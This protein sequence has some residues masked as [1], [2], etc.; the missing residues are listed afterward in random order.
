MQLKINIRISAL[1]YYK[2]IHFFNGKANIVV[3]II[4]IVTRICGAQ[5][6]VSTNATFIIYTLGIYIIQHTSMV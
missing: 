3:S 5:E 4:D 2:C 1:K 6:G